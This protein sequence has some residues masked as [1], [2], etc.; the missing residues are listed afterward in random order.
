MKCKWC[1]TE[2]HFERTPED[3]GGMIVETATGKD[4]Q[5]LPFLEW[6]K[7]KNL[8]GPTLSYSRY[9]LW[10]LGPEEAEK[11]IDLQNKAREPILPFLP[12]KLKFKKKPVSEM[13]NDKIVKVY[14]EE[15][16]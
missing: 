7:S 3:G 6:E 16:S 15:E 9:E 14:Y 13:W 1:G 11:R 2:V 4:H 8:T 10:T 12:K 5:C